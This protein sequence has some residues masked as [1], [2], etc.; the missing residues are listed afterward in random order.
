MRLLILRKQT[1]LA[2]PLRCR[3]TWKMLLKTQSLLLGFKALLCLLS[4]LPHLLGTEI[5]ATPRT[6]ALQ[7]G[8][9]RSQRI[10]RMSLV[11]KAM[12]FKP[13]EGLG[14]LTPILTTSRKMSIGTMLLLS[15]LP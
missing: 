14:A 3:R 7:G 1:C 4:S 11:Q 12:V 8:D 13:G 9:Y 15:H 2:G 6:T 5:A 10:L